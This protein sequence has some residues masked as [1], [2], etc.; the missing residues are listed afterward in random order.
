[1][2][3]LLFTWL[4]WPRSY[5]PAKY[6][7]LVG[8]TKA[9]VDEILGSGTSRGVGQDEDGYYTHYNG[10]KIRYFLVH[11]TKNDPAKDDRVKAVEPN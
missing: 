5:N 11:G 9:E 8:K 3:F 4:T 1:M 10:M 2:P 6:Q 7:T